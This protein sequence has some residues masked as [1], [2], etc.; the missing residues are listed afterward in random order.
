LDYV[1]SLC[2]R[3]REICPEFPGGPQAIHWSV[4]DPTREPG[5]DDETMPGFERTAAELE[6]RMSFLLKAIE[7]TTGS[8][9]VTEHA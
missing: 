5:T 7:H 3:V 4:R 6:T 1:I 9:V 8:Q 2:D